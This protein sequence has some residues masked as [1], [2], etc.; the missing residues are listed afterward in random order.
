MDLTTTARPADED[1]R[2]DL[3]GPAAPEALTR[4]RQFLDEGF[5][6]D[7]AIPPLSDTDASLISAL[8]LASIAESLHQIA[9]AS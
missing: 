6:Y 7:P 9:R 3:D 4:L 8:A 5:G 1:V 2:P